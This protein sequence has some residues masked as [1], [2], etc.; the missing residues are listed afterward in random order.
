MASIAPS[1]SNV[2][3]RA[4]SAVPSRFWHWWTGELA[5]LVPIR[6]KKWLTGDAPVADIAIDGNAL[7]AVRA[8]ANS[9][10]ELRRAAVMGEGA[11]AIR[12]AAQT[13][14]RDVPRDIRL[15]L[16]MNHLLIKSISLPTAT[17]EN[18]RDV[19]GFDMDRQT[20][21]T[22]TQVYYGGRVVG[23]DAN[24]ER[25]DVQLTVVP[26]HVVDPWLNGLREAGFY[27]QSLVAANELA[28]NVQA[29]ELL[30]LDARAKRRFNGV[31]RLNFALLGIALVMGLAAVFVPIWQ[32]RQAVIALVPLADKARVEFEAT[33]KV[34]AQYKLLAEEQNFLV[35]KKHATTPTVMILDELAKIF[36]DTTWVQTLDLKSTSK[37]REISLTGEATSASKVVE[38]LEQSPLLQ[39][40]KQPN[41]TRGSQPNLERFTV[42]TE[43]KPRPLPTPLPAGL[44]TVGSVT[45]ATTA[46]TP[47]AAPA[48]TPT[49]AIP[50]V[51]TVTP[52]NASAANAPN[53]NGKPGMLQPPVNAAPTVPTVSAPAPTP[54][55]PTPTFVP[56]P[57]PKPTP[58][59]SIPVAGGGQGQSQATVTFPPPSAPPTAPPPGK[60]P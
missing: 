26:K 59:A 4:V 52:I 42:A 12:S 35:G 29:V 7:V 1:L 18:L 58:Q 10:R 39:N 14:A 37:A 31:Q 34:E 36:P 5:A 56:A 15:A 49:T 50:A 11:A 53:A 19:L 21:F 55:A 46:T 24:H 57:V 30:P 48:T 44:D 32:K 6:L 43:V 28:P 47:A 2:A 27:V 16:P 33:Q 20:P 45:P 54:Q 3:G 13:L 17:E 51:A 8:E 25:I 60:S 9:V 40:A 41:A 38:A 22:A 23:R